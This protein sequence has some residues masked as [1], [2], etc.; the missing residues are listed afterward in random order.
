VL[1]SFI[2]GS[3][4]AT[5]SFRNDTQT[6]SVALTVT[7]KR[8]SD[9]AT[10]VLVS[11]FVI[12]KQQ[13]YCAPPMLATSWPSDFPATVNWE[14]SNGLPD[15]NA[16]LVMGPNPAW[17][18]AGSPY[19]DILTISA[20][21]SM[22][23]YDTYFPLYAD[24]TKVYFN[25]MVYNTGTP[26]WLQISFMEDGTVARYFDIKPNWVGWK[27]VS[28][29]YSDLKASNIDAA[30][31]IQPQ[32]VTAIQIVMLSSLA[33]TDPNLMVTPVKAAFDHM[34]FTHNKPYQP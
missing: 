4:T 34:T 10:D 1:P 19:V 21:N 13:C 6:E 20:P 30:N 18:G 23:N 27:L 5:L 32:K 24:P 26:T 12:N 3:V 2:A 11:D 9:L 33:V 7:A 29:K 28:I 17:Q 16:Y 22:G 14:I 25:V 31:N 8:V 15:G